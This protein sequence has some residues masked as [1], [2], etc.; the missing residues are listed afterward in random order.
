MVLDGKSAV[1]SPR[2]KRYVLFNTL[3]VNRLDGVLKLSTTSC[4]RLQDKVR[5]PVG[6]LDQQVKKECPTGRI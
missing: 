4:G 2:M 3:F 1:K 6:A 5:L